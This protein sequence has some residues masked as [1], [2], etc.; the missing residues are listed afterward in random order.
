MNKPNV[1]VDVLKKMIARFVKAA[2]AKK[3]EPLDPL[4]RLIRAF[5][6][7]DCDEARTTRGGA[8]DSWRTWWISMSCA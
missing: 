1:K 4:A 8:Q 2:P 5:L 6:E 3:P 7:Y